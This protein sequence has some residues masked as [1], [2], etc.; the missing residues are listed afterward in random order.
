MKNLPAR[1]WLRQD[2]HTNEVNS[3]LNTQQ[4]S[5]KEKLQRSLQTQQ[6]WSKKGDSEGTSMGVYFSW[7]CAYKKHVQNMVRAHGQACKKIQAL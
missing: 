6:K 7:G 3:K 1:T 4:E 5:V 2:K